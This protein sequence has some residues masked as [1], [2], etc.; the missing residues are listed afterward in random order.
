MARL[1]ITAGRGCQPKLKKAVDNGM[2]SGII[3]L[4]LVMQFFTIHQSLFISYRS[5][6]TV[7]PLLF[8]FGGEDEPAQKGRAPERTGPSKAKKEKKAE[9]QS[10][11]SRGR[12]RGEKDQ[13][14]EGSKSRA[15]VSDPS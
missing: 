6:F 12:G 11:R 4:K 8:L 10:E 9:A 1:L 14:A 5:P 7:Y 3:F 2:E 13:I 15:A